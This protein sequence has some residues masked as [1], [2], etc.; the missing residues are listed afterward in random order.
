MRA[1]LLAAGMGTRLNSLT[2]TTPKPLIEING[3][4]L[5]ERQIEML[6]E[7]KVGEI[8]V[9]TGYLKDKFAY[10][11]D[12]YGVKLVYNDKY[13]LFN[14]I[15]TMY[16]VREYLGNSYVLDADVYLNENF[17]SENPTSSTYYCANKKGFTD[18]WKVNFDTENNLKSIE[19]VSGDGYIL[20]GV[21]FWSKEDGVKIREKLE[22]K[23][24][25]GNFKTLYW[26]DIV[27]E[28]IDILKIKIQKMKEN[29]V[30]EVDNIRDLEE[31]KRR[32]LAGG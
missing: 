32:V 30:F 28:N 11:E 10:L 23:I 12:K 21:S 14:N 18:E 17:I 19:I 4:P 25:S 9:L 16:L 15:Y 31:V 20:S 29:S 7:K 22:Q 2:I 13:A 8:I 1:I 27:R 26:D 5:I 24:A 3:A 6:K